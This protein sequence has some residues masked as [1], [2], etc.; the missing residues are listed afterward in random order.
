MISPVSLDLFYAAPLRL[1]NLEL[2][3]IRLLGPKSRLGGAEKVGRR[4]HPKRIGVGVLLVVDNLDHVPGFHSV[5]EPRREKRENVLEDV[6]PPLT[7]EVAAR[8]GRPLVHDVELRQA[9]LEHEPGP[10][11]DVYKRQPLPGGS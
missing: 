1:E 6:P 4:R 9:I 5:P 10:P 7:L 11:V 3:A 2:L 8:V